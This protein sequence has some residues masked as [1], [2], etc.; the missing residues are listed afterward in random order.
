[1]NAADTLRNVQLVD[2]LLK[3]GRA[4]LAKQEANLLSAE[5]RN[6]KRDIFVATTMISREKKNIDRL[7]QDRKELYAQYDNNREA[8]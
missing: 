7:I 5:K 6:N 4:R 2:V 3:Q 1:M 8:A